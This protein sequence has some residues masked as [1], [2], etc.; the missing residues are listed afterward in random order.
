MFEQY[1][2]L[3]AIGNTPIVK[4]ED[5]PSYFAKLEGFN[6]FG[7]IKDRAVAY[8]IE[9]AYQDKLIT[10][11]S[12]LIES[13][14]GNF[15]IALAAITKIYGN[16]CICVIDKNVTPL[17]RFILDAFGAQIVEVT[18]YDE[19][20]SSLNCRLSTVKKMLSENANLYWINQYDNRF[21]QDA[22]YETIGLELSQAFANIDYLF[23]PVSTCGTIAGLSR[24]IKKT[25]PLA[26]VIAVDVKGS[27][28]FSEDTTQKRHI[29][30]M[31][32]SIRPN[33]LNQAIIDDIILINEVDAIHHCRM[34][35]HKSLLVGGSSGAVSAAIWKYFNGKN[36]DSIIVGI[37]P[38][39]G[40]RYYNNVFDS[41]WCDENI[42]TERKGN[43]CVIR[44]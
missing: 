32:A 23:V 16:K 5:S 42:I 33:N 43:H 4:I 11:E 24:K 38:D 2:L 15:A 1:S 30:G 3:S 34:L 10:S 29:P 25:N 37:F 9:K 18:E 41:T 39:R 26:K 12:V 31:G 35:L 19:N 8:V 20:G 36:T 40:E 6:P 7:S 17:N 14:S 13:S 22:Y 21:M 27:K 44:G 28:I